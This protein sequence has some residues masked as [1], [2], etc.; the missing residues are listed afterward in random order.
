MLRSCMR[1]SASLLRIGRVVLVSAASMAST[2]LLAESA[3]DSST[4]A[5]PAPPSPESVAS[6][7]NANLS[8]SCGY[9]SQGAT[10][11]GPGSNPNAYGACTRPPAAD[12]GDDASAAGPDG[13]EGDYCC[14]NWSAGACTPD[15]QAAC[16]PGTYGFSCPAGHG[17]AEVDGNWKCPLGDTGGAAQCCTYSSCVPDQTVTC[18]SSL[19]GNAGWTC[20]SATPPVSGSL[21]LCS[22]GALNDSRRHRLPS[23]AFTPPA[24]R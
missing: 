20:P 15:V 16:E 9:P 6:G 22:E 12:G 18:A 7:C 10:C 14:L 21:T 5:Q 23:A 4:T 1:P 13:G 3:C 24:R 19:A 8:L 17:P 11:S 2:A